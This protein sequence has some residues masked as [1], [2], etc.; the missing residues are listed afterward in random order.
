MLSISAKN[1]VTT[2][3]TKSDIKQHKVRHKGDIGTTLTSDSDA[4][5]PGRR[6]VAATPRRLARAEIFMMM[7]D[8]KREREG[9]SSSI[10]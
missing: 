6:V 10:G 1:T 3:N 8:N 5:T 2:N 9:E 7:M 4:E